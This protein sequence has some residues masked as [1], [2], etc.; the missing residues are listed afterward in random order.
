LKTTR[1]S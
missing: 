1:W